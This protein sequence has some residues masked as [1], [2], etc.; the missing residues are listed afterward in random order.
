MRNLFISFIILLALLKTSELVS[1]CSLPSEIPIADNDTMIVSFVVEGALVDDLSLNGVCGF[2]INFTHDFV[3]DVAIS[4]ISPA[5]QEVQLI[6]PTSENSVN[7]QLVRWDINFIPCSFSSSPDPGIAA[8]WNNQNNWL[9][10]NTYTGSYYPVNGCLEDLNS[11]PVNGNWSI[12]I[13]DAVS[14]G[15]GM[16]DDVNI[17]FCN[18]SGIDCETCVVD[19]G[20]LS[21]QTMSFCEGMEALRFIPDVMYETGSLGTDNT[22]K[23]LVVDPETGGSLT[24][25]VDLSQS[26]PGVYQICGVAVNSL[27]ESLLPDA[28]G[29]NSGEEYGALI[30]SSFA[31]AAITTDCIILTI[32]DVLDTILVSEFICSGE[33]Y[34][35]NGKFYDEAGTYIVGY[36]SGNCESMTIL[37][38]QIFNLEAMI[39]GG[40]QLLSCSETSIAL[41][42]SPSIADDSISYRWFTTDG[43][44]LNDTTQ[45][46]IAI[47]QIGIYSLE[48]SSENCVDTQSVEVLDDGSFVEFDFSFDEINCNNESTLIDMSTNVALSNV[49]WT[50]VE[51][52]S[53]V[54]DNITA[55]EPGWY[56][57]EV[58]SVDGCMA[59]DSVE[60]LDG[61]DIEDPVFNPTDITCAEITVTPGGM[62]SDTTGMIFSWSGPN[63]FS[64]SLLNPDMTESGV[65]SLDIL[66]ENGCVETH[67]VVINDLRQFPVLSTINDTL[68][69]AAPRVYIGVNSSI[70]NV[71]YS[72]SGPNSFTSDEQRPRVGREGNYAVTVT[73]TA[74]CA[75]TAMLEVAKDVRLPSLGLNDLTINCLANG[76]IT[77][78]VTTDADSPSYIWNGPGGFYSELATPAAGVIGTYQVTVTGTNGCSRSDSLQLIPGND[79]PDVT[80][81]ASILT[82]DL[83]QVEIIPSDST[84]LIYEYISP[85][86]AVS[87]NIS[88]EVL[89]VGE[90]NIRVTDT[91]SC[92]TDYIYEVESDTITPVFDFRAAALNCKND[93]VRINPGL[94]IPIR[95][96]QWT[97][98]DSFLYA[99]QRPW[100][101]QSGF[102]YI[103]VVGEN[104]CSNSDSIRIRENYNEPVITPR[105]TFF[106][107]TPDTLRIIADVNFNNSTYQWEGPGGFNTAEDSPFIET[108][109]TYMVTVTGPNGCVSDTFLQVFYDTIAPEIVLQNDGFLTC[110]DPIVRVTAEINEM[111]TINT[112]IG[113]ED[114]IVG[115][116]F[117]DVGV[118]GV[119]RLI[120][121]DET[122]CISED[123]IMVETE[124][125]YPEINI[126]S[127]DI[128]CA[129]VFSHVDIDVDLELDS[130]VWNAPLEIQ[131]DMISFNTNV[132]GI[133]Q[134]EAF[135]KN[136]CDSTYSF[137]I[138]K[139]TIPPDFS[140]ISP[141]TI[142][143]NS[144]SVSLSL[145]ND[146]TVSKYLW[147]GPQGFQSENPNP[148][149]INGGI[150][151]LQAIGSNGCLKAD[152]VTVAIDTLSPFVDGFDNRITCLNGRPRLEVVTNAISPIYNWTGPGDYN[153]DEANPRAVLAGNYTVEVFS[154][155]G[156]SSTTT[157][158]LID[159]TEPV[160]ITLDSVSYLLCDSSGVNLEVISDE[161]N[162]IYNWI[163][164]GDFFSV[165]QKPFVE[166][167]GIYQ[168]YATG[169]N[170][171]QARKST[172]V[173]VDTRVPEF[174][175]SAEVLTCT[176]F[177]S[178][179][180]AVAV[181]DDANWRWS[182]PNGFSSQETTF[183]VQDSGQY[184]LIVQGMNLCI[185]TQSVS[186]I[187]DREDPV[188]IASFDEILQCE[189]NEVYVDGSASTGAHALLYEWATDNGL[190]ISGA[191]GARPLVGEEGLYTLMVTDAVNECTSTAAVSVN[192]TEQEFED[193]IVEVN[194][195]T[196]EG[197][198]NGEIIIS[199]FVGGYGPY[200]VSFDGGTFIS[201]RNFRFLSQGNYQL[202]IE[203]SLGCRIEKEYTIDPP[204]VLSLDIGEDIF[205]D[206]GDSVQMNVISNVAEDEIA[207]LDWS[208]GGS[209]P[210]NDCFF[211]YI[212]PYAPTTYRLTLTDTNGCMVS[213]ERMISVEDFPDLAFPNIFRPTS[214]SG[215]ERF[216]I[217]Q[218][219]GIKNIN[220]LSIYDRW[221]NRMFHEE[222]FTPGDAEIGWNGEFNG[223]KMEP[224]V[225]AVIAEVVLENDR[226]V[227]VKSDLTLIR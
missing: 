3:G 210:C 211:Q 26:S 222:N 17:V 54:G 201:K 64:S 90:F 208:G 167:V 82:C 151:I 19:P 190:I 157:L 70:S 153:S 142:T 92:F 43:N 4:I 175:L 185:D 55:S 58:T 192:R 99:E 45:S 156:C 10:F 76:S 96:Y 144:P 127:N 115:V 209:V 146:T 30:E 134:L 179:V 34:E 191:N 51:T 37:D 8:V 113:A 150:Y 183:E 206:F 89:E 50:S 197:F 86:G 29:I 178:T 162:T 9:Q 158:E 103:A 60:I 174:E 36:S 189:V 120:A 149:V 203:D 2:N 62:L 22:Y 221:G 59:R 65:Y 78:N 187:I 213:D 38:L 105:D 196:C 224:A 6:G 125:Q 131:K 111:N 163:G 169:E 40:D 24:D 49:R 148:D 27:Q 77:L 216:Y 112:W 28:S 177:S 25:T 102:Y 215:N 100:V 152:T 97:G 136:G 200:Y 225:F 139:D 75:S 173:E 72:W 71:T 137:E 35:I 67:N 117:I 101:D 116:S 114:T 41:D 143:C 194:R 186:V 165:E 7:S 122:G 56:F 109:G 160:H 52:F 188:A 180:R 199:D 212:T 32:E 80:F 147:I 106:S 214:E 133:Y 154:I 91:M 57:V 161:L 164:P 11:G 39:A 104:G 83:P 48:V 85:T 176:D 68:T 1:Q 170:G 31:C 172:R 5:G 129:V 223:D 84:G 74:Q 18:N 145:E 107:C 79:V 166:S 207:N 130:L 132:A 15:E 118:D 46:T 126:T 227:L 182:G 63:G 184:A 171:C 159:D 44:I 123:S 23:Y 195:P 33:V 124:I 47:N 95:N 53:R 202:V 119:W 198:D 155:N 73:T 138:L 93:S 81:D 218:T 217:P 61:F 88:P 168:V 226:V 13:I 193:I 12:Q 121:E 135:G 98:P 108:D 110:P 204:K 219:K 220:Y 69:C 140:F 87:N 141:D 21:D 205:I 14:F 42:G 181:E 94:N 66:G 128:N 16:I 20:E